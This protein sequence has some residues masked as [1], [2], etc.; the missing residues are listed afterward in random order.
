MSNNL[1][2]EERRQNEI[3]HAES[4]SVCRILGLVVHAA[5]RPDLLPWGLVCSLAFAGLRAAFAIGAVMCGWYFPAWSANISVE[6]ISNPDGDPD[7]G[8]NPGGSVNNNCYVLRENMWG[9]LWA[10][11]LPMHGVFACAVLYGPR[12]CFSE[13]VFFWLVGVLTG[14]VFVLQLPPVIQWSE[15]VTGV[16]Q[17]SIRL[18][19]LVSVFAGFMGAMKAKPGEGSIASKS[20]ED[21]PGMSAKSSRGEV[22]VSVPRDEVVVPELLEDGKVVSAAPNFMGGG[23]QEITSTIQE[24]G[25]ERSVGESG[26]GAGNFDEH[27]NA[28]SKNAE[29]IKYFNRGIHKREYV[30]I[31]SVIT[32]QDGAGRE[33]PPRGESARELIK[34]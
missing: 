9:K 22:A 16:G 21:E 34:I 7:C 15:A 6:A 4:L 5:V 11:V 2:R 31:S 18:S 8:K 17:F 1:A 20:R 14:I 33:F 30:S 3:L 24:S 10:I 32:G 26:N 29:L 28:R 13:P 12:A 23:Q 19:Q 27:I 25:G